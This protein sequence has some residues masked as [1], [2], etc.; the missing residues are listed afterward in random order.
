MPRLLIEIGTEEI[1]AGYIEPALSALA[2]ILIRRLT[3]ARLDYGAPPA[4]YGTPRRLAVSVENLS[5]AQRPITTE[6]LGPPERVAFDAL[7]KPTVAARKFAEKIGIPLRK[8]TLKRTEKGN[9]LCA[10]QTERGLAAQTL[11]RT[12]IPEIILSIPFPKSMR[13]SNL[14]VEFVRPIHSLLALFGDRVIPFAIGNIRSGRH[15]FGHRFMKPGRLKIGSASEYSDSL[16]SAYVLA[17]IEERKEKLSKSVEAAAGALGGKILRDEELLATVTHLVE[18][19]AVAAGAFET[20]YLE[21]PKEILITAMREHQ[22]YFSVADENGS[23]LPFFV[24]VNNTPA[25]EMSVVARGHERVL[26]AR[27]EDARFFYRSDISIPFETRVE[28]L[29]GVMFQAKLGSMHEKTAR[30]QQLSRFLAGKI[31]GGPLPDERRSLLIETVARA[32]WLS[33]ADLVSL[34]VS[35]FPKLQGIMGRIYAAQAGEP[36]EVAAAIEEHY[37]PTHSG[38]P[39]PET[40]AGAVLSIADKI[41]SIC[42]C[43]SAGL[44]PTGTSD[45][46]ALRRQGIGILQTVVKH[47]FSFSV[48]EM[49][50]KS[51][52]LF[53][54]LEENEIEATEEKVK[55]FFHNRMTH[56]LIE[57]GY[58]K[59]TVAAV[60]S[61]FPEDAIDAWKKAHALEKFRSQPGFAPLSIAFKRVANIIRKIDEAPQME[62]SPEERV[63]EEFFRH[64][65]ETSL[66]RSFLAAEEIVLDKLD[67]GSHEDALS[68]LSDLRDPVDTFFEGVMVMTQEADV[69]K[70][71]LLLLRKISELFSRFADFTK[72]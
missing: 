44:I 9:Y 40:T 22:K 48:S 57:E 4:V 20:K 53:L 31:E 56:L 36:T 67:R 28:K 35:E 37:R 39:L 71:R 70:N 72:L 26:R 7:G 54:N 43:F 64:E 10:A 63:R 50:K 23:L 15:S 2:S 52:R 59:D 34:I 14:E 8:T 62:G 51:I 3:E 38:A 1:P 11:L 13:W 61:R 69:R 68:A 46:Y 42:G 55:Q 30:I 21:L 65:S 60:L 49:I 16:R 66:Y 32:A 33:K 24:S 18:Y 6:K 45:P 41:D 5:T 17:D 47:R 58:S 12:V 29:K 25:R 27:L 19:P